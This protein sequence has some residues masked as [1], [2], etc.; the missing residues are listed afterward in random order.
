MSMIDAFTESCDVYYYQVGLV[1]GMDIINHVAA[2]FGFGDTTGIDLDDERSGMLIDSASYTRKFKKRGWR[3]TR[4]LVLNLSIGQG[5]LATP[6]QLAN[7]AAGLANGKVVYKPHFLKE[8]KDRAGNRVIQY[9][10]QVLHHLEM[11]PDQHAVILKAMESVVNGPRGTGGRSRVPDVIVGGKTGSSENPHGGLT[12][13]LFIGAA[14]L[15][16]PEL[17]IAVV[18]EN[19]GHGGSFAAPIAGAIFREYFKR[20]M[21]GAQQQVL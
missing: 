3:W 21:A 12:H 2:D 7:Y 1:I 6:L 11:T 10:P 5:Q 16:Q 14:P 4:G 18:L 15:Y 19:V 13:A 8:I 20:K 17:A 9:Q